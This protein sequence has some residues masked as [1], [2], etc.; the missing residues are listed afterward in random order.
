M[1]TNRPQTRFELFS[2]EL[3]NVQMEKSTEKVVS[4]FLC[5]NGLLYCPPIYQISKQTG[6]SVQAVKRAIT[7]GLNN[8]SLIQH[9]FPQKSAV[10]L[11]KLCGANRY[12]LSVSNTNYL[13]SMEIEENKMP[14]FEY[15]AV[16]IEPEYEKFTSGY[17]SGNS[18]ET[19]IVEKFKLEY[20]S[21]H[22]KK[23]TH[24]T[25]Q[26]FTLTKKQLDFA[27]GYLYELYLNNIQQYKE[28]NVLNSRINMKAEF[29]PM[30]KSDARK[31]AEIYS[32]IYW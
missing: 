3:T 18:F 27:V 25:S 5:S 4:R 2:Y 23:K 31:Y 10:W 14:D 21:S 1:T 8:G 12:R 22:S 19:D 16:F 26:Y 11:I 9:S 28:K 32:K 17:F 13:K 15:V 20:L 30:Q 7:L 6:L 24:N 29:L